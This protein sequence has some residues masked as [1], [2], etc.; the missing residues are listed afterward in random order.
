MKQ[1]M[2]KNSEVRNENPGGPMPAD[3]MKVPY[4]LALNEYVFCH[5]FKPLQ[6]SY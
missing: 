4:N 3:S 1:F 5:F 6:I 2:I